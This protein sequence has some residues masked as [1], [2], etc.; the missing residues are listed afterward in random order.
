MGVIEFFKPVS[1]LGADELRELLATRH[2]DDVQIVDVRPSSEYRKSHLPGA[3][4][5]PL[6]E[7]PER[8][9]DLEA[10]R[11]TIICCRSGLRSRAAAALLQG[12]GFDRVLILEEGLDAWEGHLAEGRLQPEQFPFSAVASL[13]EF[14]ALAWYMEDAT[15]EFYLHVVD[16]QS[17]RAIKKLFGRLVEDEQRHK[18]T[19]TAL[20][21]VFLEPRE[22]KNFPHSI[23]PEFPGPRLLEGGYR[24][25]A[26]RQWA[27]SCGA[28]EIVEL[29]L[30]IEINAFD[31]YQ[32]LRRQVSDENVRRILEIIAGDERRHLQSLDDARED[33]CRERDFS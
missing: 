24:L 22:R 27:E 25:S 3:V 5:I 18:E 19:L 13:K 15:R 7:L 10:D 28:D 14:I 32:S 11:M 31:R 8:A 33:L 17:S 23:I 2:P 9:E 1:G 20:A 30:T 4:S 21:D 6:A 16:A 29:A 26:A 12:A